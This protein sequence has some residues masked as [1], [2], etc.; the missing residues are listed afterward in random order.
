MILNSCSSK[1]SDAPAQCT[2]DPPTDLTIHAGRLG[3]SFAT[4]QLPDVVRMS[5]QASCVK[6]S[7][8]SLTKS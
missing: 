5:F 4:R 1:R 6:L 7:H 2:V 8:S 3:K